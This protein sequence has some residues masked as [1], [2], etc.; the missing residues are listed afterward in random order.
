MIPC[1]LKFS[2]LFLWSTLRHTLWTLDVPPMKFCSVAS[3]KLSMIIFIG[4]PFCA[5]NYIILL[6]KLSLSI[7]GAISIW[8]ARTV[9]HVNKQ[10][11]RFSILCQ[12]CAVKG[13]KMTT[14]KF[15]IGVEAPSHS[16]G[17]SAVTGANVCALPL[18]HAIRFF[19]IEGEALFTPIVQ[20]GCWTVF[21]TC[22][23][24][25][26]WLFLCS[27]RKICLTFPM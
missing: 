6:R 14:S 25:S 26:Y 24:P 9:R 3:K 10:H 27:L 5:E 8:T 12:I 13:L 15:A 16:V 22:W 18:R 17:S 1:W 19:S 11:H 7:F 4:V 21:L 20:T 2:S 23:V